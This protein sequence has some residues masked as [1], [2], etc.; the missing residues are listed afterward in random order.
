MSTSEPRAD[1]PRPERRLARALGCCSAA[2]GVPQVTMPGRVNRLLGVKDDDDSRTWQR[3]VGGRELAAAAGLLT[4]RRPVGWLWARV[5]GD[6]M[7]LALL[8][9]AMN[10]KDA[11]PGRIRVAMGAVAGIAA[12]DVYTA[13]R[14]TRSREPAGV[15]E[16]DRVRGAVT[17][18]RPRAEAYVFWQDFENLP[19]FMAHLESVVL[20]GDGRTRWVAIAPGGGRMRWDA[21]I[22][23]FVPDE[24]IAWRSV[25]G[26]DVDSEGVVRFVPAPGGRGTEV[27]LEMSY[28]APGGRAGRMIA[29]LFGADAEQQVDEDLR[30]FKQVMETGE[31]VRS[32]GSPEGIHAGRLLRQRPAQPL[33]EPVGAGARSA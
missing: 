1:A 19:S 3:I 28:S 23:D 22:I 14:M 6:A 16:R 9:A 27:R 12:V 11:R 24:L 7:D 33:R 25:K 20:V 18:R 17:V 15:D 8:R 26:G 2:L 21:E 13:V 4:R 5:A 31:V 30:R 29:R 10:E 32:E